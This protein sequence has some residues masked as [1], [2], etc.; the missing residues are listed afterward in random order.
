MSEE[1]LVLGGRYQLDEIIGRGGMAEVWRAHD[2][3]LDR[4][5]AVKRLRVDLATDSTF[6]ARFQREAQSAAGLNHPNIVSVYDTGEK[7][8]PAT[9][10]SVPY[11]VMELVEGHTLREILRQGRTIQP[12]K[13]FEYTMG[14]LDALSYSH[15]HDIVHRDIKPANVMITPNGQIKVMDF[16]IAR[17]VSDTSATMTQ[18]AAVIGTAQYLSP[19]QARGE[20]VDA[21]SDI[22]SA[23]CLLYE[24]LT[25]RPPFIGDSPVSVAYQ[26]VREIPIPPSQLDAE[27]TAEMDAVTMKA[28]A[29]ATEDRYQSAKAMR[30]D[31]IRLLNGQSVTAQIPAVVAASEP[32]S[33]SAAPTRALPAAED[34]DAYYADDY[35]DELDYEEQPEQK[36]RRVSP[37]TL[38]LISLLVLLLGALAVFAVQLFR[39]DPT[40]NEVQ[41]PT[42]VGFEEE[43]ARETLTL[44]QLNPVVERVPGPAEGKGT[45][46]SQDPEGGQPALV[47]STVTITI[48]DGPPVST[49]P[50]GLLGKPQEEAVALLKEAGFTKVE[51]LPATSDLDR[52]GAKKGE[53]VKVDP[54]EGEDLA[55]DQLVKLYV[56]SGKDTVPDVTGQPEAEARRIL[57]DAGYTNISAEYVPHGREPIDFL[58]GQV[59]ETSPAV[60]SELSTESPIVLRLATGESV[61][62]NV[63]GMTRDEAEAELKDRLGFT[64]VHFEERESAADEAG[65]V[66]GQ[67]VPANEARPREY[68][69]TI[70]LGQTTLPTTEPTSDP[71]DADGDSG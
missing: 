56:A 31:C 14:V 45:V 24:L 55:T 36:R 48:N 22:Y 10:V 40:E 15:K 67:S 6:Q 9:N 52:V 66:V 47:G 20:Q 5:V 49:I 33:S 1:P 64:N 60:G 51:L 4:L 58:R 63:L 8:D 18:T 53:V 21:R 11:I 7:V 34:P 25:G 69:I 3:R 32:A 17:A 59:V 13:A 57:A 54:E 27:I 71:T 61:M 62:T 37:A 46:I 26:H 23:G 19:E 35:D 44:A 41:V 68:A 30:D 29:K 38:V 16:G 65:K 28:L 43:A 39:P 50:A 12:E 70:T 2:L 42:V